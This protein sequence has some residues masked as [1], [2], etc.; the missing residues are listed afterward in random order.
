M[1]NEA[2]R[3]CERREHEPRHD[4]VERR[5]Q[6]AEYRFDRVVAVNESQLRIGLVGLGDIAVRAHLPAIAAEA[7]A[8]LVAV[9][10]A[11]ADR[12]AAFAPPGARAWADA[13]ALFAAPDIDAVVIATPP[14]ATAELVRA[15]LEA[16]KYVLAE[17]PLALSV[18]AAADIRDTR[19]AAERL[20]IG[21]TYRHHPAV[22]RLRELIA[23]GAL[24]R[25]LLIQAAICDERADPAGDPLGH[26]RRLR[27]LERLPPVVSDGV[28]ACDRL[29]YLLGETPVDVSGWSLRTD[30]G[31]AS[32]N[33]NG[34]VLTYA[35]GTVARLEVVWMVPVLPPSQFVVTGPLG[36][37][38]LDPP[39]FRLTVE[40]AD[41]T[42]ETLEPPGDKTE[43]CFAFQ[44]ER[45]VGH[46]L[47]G[48]APVPG[49]DE[50]LASL[51]LAERIAEAAGV[52]REVPA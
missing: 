17:K 45:F 27:S 16:G 32:A 50:A 2:D 38:T 33:V 39:T 28:H 44:L 48:T 13:D 31:F 20:Q 35:D 51:G 7:R 52:A 37:A 42:T 8:V 30:P 6:G 5:T 4:G 12:L 9:A 46:C 19:G 25:P 15:A 14:A 11:D 40:L 41:G 43:T 23:A 36:R 21:L 22:D 26:A 10:D 3:R 1:D 24:G 29:N 18:A 47:A 49:L 34:G